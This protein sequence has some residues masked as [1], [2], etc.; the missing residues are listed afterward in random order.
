METRRSAS[1]V[2]ASGEMVVLGIADDRRLDRRVGMMGVRAA[3][4]AT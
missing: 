4:A 3:N 2:R 1:A